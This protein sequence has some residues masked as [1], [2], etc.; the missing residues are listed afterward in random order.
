MTKTLRLSALLL[1]AILLLMSFAACGKNNSGDSSDDKLEG[2]YRMTD[3]SGS[4][5]DMYEEY[6]DE[7][8]LSIDSNNIG[9][10]KIKKGSLELSFNADKETVSFEGSE[11]VPYTFDGKVLK[12][13][14][15][16]AMMEFTK[17]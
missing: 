12:I 4:G 13:Q 10:M 15:S 11:E 3:V 8:T 2:S 14:D 1:A 17:E 16:T 6:M 9:Q 7:I 5:A